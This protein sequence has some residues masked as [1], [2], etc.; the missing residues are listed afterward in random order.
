MDKSS[1]KCGDVLSKGSSVLSLISLLIIVALY[2]RMESINGKTE[3]NE[4]RISRL[5]SRIEEIGSTQKTDH[6]NDM[7]T[8]EGKY[9]VLVIAS[10]LIQVN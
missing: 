6:K 9:R 3:M 5:K 2:L 4:L 1:P 10:C 8:P 7:A